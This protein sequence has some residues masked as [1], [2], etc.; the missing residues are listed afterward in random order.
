ML[1]QVCSTCQS[2]YTLNE[3]V[4]HVFEWGQC[5][6]CWSKTLEDQKSS[7]QQLGFQA[8]KIIDDT[9][10][11]RE[12]RHCLSKLTE[13]ERIAFLYWCGRASHQ[14]I[15]ATSEPPWHLFEIQNVTGSLDET[16]ADFC[17]MVVNFG[18]PINV[19]LRQLEKMA[20]AKPAIY[21][22]G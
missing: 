4:S 13:Y 3:K 21:V 5:P 7:D 10:T 15:L 8:L 19:C 12:I 17:G 1:S 9:D 22:P 16:I 18:L 14:F 2:Q 11:M 6:A 20:S